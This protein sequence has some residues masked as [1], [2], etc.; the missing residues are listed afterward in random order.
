MDKTK[1]QKN[2]SYIYEYKLHSVYETSS[3]LNHKIFALGSF[4]SIAP[5]QTP[6]VI[7]SHV[8]RETMYHGSKRS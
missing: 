7:S 5:I 6:P 4:L 8:A 2:Q 3:K 1:G